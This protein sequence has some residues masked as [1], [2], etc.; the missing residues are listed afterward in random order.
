MGWKII[1]ATR[2][3]RGEIHGWLR[4]EIGGNQ[5]VNKEIEKFASL[6]NR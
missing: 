1:E 5:I 2:V 4:T 6:I 3:K